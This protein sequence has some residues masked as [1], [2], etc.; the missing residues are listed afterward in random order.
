MGDGNLEDKLFGRVKKGLLLGAL[1]LAVLFFLAGAPPV[2]KA[3]EVQVEGQKQEQVVGIGLEAYYDNG[4]LEVSLNSKKGVKY[5]LITGNGRR[6]EVIQ[7]QIGDGKPIEFLLD[8][9]PYKLS[10]GDVIDLNVVNSDKKVFWLEGKDLNGFV[11][12]YSEGSTRTPPAAPVAQGLAGNN[13]TVYWWGDVPDV[14]QYRIYLN[15]TDDFGTAEYDDCRGSFCDLIGGL[16]YVND[17]GNGYSTI[18][19]ANG[20]ALY[21]WVTGV[22][23]LGEESVPSNTVGLTPQSNQKIPRIDL[24]NVGGECDV[25]VIVTP[26]VGDY[27]ITSGTTPDSLSCNPEISCNEPSCYTTDHVFNLKDLGGNITYYDVEFY[28]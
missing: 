11:V 17:Q 16:R 22:N 1:E 2:A 19:P 5:R 26:P 4:Y 14:Q 25:N 15:T 8:V 6:N 9:M 3:E 28:D 20:T 7:E 10:E 27:Y 13:R 18:Q 12:D 21:C 23:G 24:S